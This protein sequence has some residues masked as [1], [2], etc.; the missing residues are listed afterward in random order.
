MYSPGCYQVF[1]QQS[2]TRSLL[3]FC[4]HW[5]GTWTV[6][7]ESLLF[8][9]P[10]HA[11]LLVFLCF[12][13]FLS[14][15][16]I[17]S[18]FSAGQAEPFRFLWWMCGRILLCAD[19]VITEETTSLSMQWDIWA[20]S[21][22]F[23]YMPHVKYC[24]ATSRQNFPE[25]GCCHSMVQA[26]YLSTFSRT[27]SASISREIASCFCLL[28]WRGEKGSACRTILQL[29]VCSVFICLPLVRGKSGSLTFISHCN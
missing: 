24:V 7:T 17:M 16:W 13:F 29:P 21:Q 12:L 25:V 26:C 18:V 11:Y 9:P 3:Y 28:L 22:G 20:L 23:V 4:D 2:T 6:W 14:F 27:G 10:S 8:P 15:L 5:R 19:L 1:L